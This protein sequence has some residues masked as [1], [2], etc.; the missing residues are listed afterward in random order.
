MKR[1]AFRVKD[2]VFIAILSAAL[3]LS[4]LI[5]MPLVMSISLFGIRN[6]ASALLYSLFVM[7]GLMKV[8]KPGTL[9]LIGFLHG[10]VLLMMAP[11]M[12][13]S[14]FIGAFLTECIA[15]LIF[16]HYDKTQAQIFAATLFIPMT[17]PMTLIFTMVIH[18]LSFSE[19]LSQPLLAVL[20]SVA[21]VALSY[22]GSKLGAKIGNELKKAGK[23]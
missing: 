12:F 21:T 15:L 11:V 22:I 5:T 7:L 16:K 1:S 10:S 23:I 6:M 2:V 8:Q 13:W 9:T 18:G 14:M 19:I 20:L 4:G 3:T 17:L